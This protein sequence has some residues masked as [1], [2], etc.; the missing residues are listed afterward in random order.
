MKR[1][2]AVSVLTLA[3]LAVTAL[4]AA[5]QTHVYKTTMTFKVSYDPATEV[6][7]TSGR[8]TSSEGPCQKGREVYIAVLPDYETSETVKTKAN[9]EFKWTFRSNDPSELEVQAYADTRILKRAAGDTYKCGTVAKK[10]PV[11]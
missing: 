5:A 7:T 2:L 3:A 9:G 6:V 8:L 4:P 10:A 1:L 11:G